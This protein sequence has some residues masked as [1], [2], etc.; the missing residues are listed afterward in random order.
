MSTQ[1]KTESQLP[2]TLDLANLTQENVPELLALARAKIKEIKGGSDEKEVKM[3]TTNFPGIGDLSKDDTTPADL[4]KAHSSI[5]KRMAAYAE[6]CDALGVKSNK[7]PFEESKVKGE[8]WLAFIEK[9]FKTVA[10]LKELK[11]YEE[12]AKQLEQVLSEKDKLKNTLMN[13]TS[14]FQED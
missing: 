7:Y 13:I 2:V 4:I 14:I 5:V 3:A 12:A 9:R 1:T 8:V 6:S 10:N 11:K